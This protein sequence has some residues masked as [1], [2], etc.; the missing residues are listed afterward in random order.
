LLKENNNLGGY[1]TTFKSVAHARELKQR[2]SL[3]VKG[4]AVVETAD[5]AG[6]PIAKYTK[7]AEVIWVKIET[8]P[9]DSAL[10]DALGLAQRVYSPHRVQILR[11]SDTISDAGFRELMTAACAKLG[12]KLEIWQQATLPASF[13]LSAATKAADIAAD[14]INPLMS[15]Q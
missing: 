13:D 1:V 4:L 12:M 2:L 11:D 15:S 5:A 10:T 7:G 3:Q 6:N 14:E 8:L 9:N